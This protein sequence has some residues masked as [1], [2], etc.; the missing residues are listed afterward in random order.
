[1]AGGKEGMRADGLTPVSEI[2]PQQFTALGLK[3]HGCAQ[4]DLWMAALTRGDGDVVAYQFDLPVYAPDGGRTTP[5][6]VFVAASVLREAWRPGD[7]YEALKP[8]RAAIDK[9]LAVTSAQLAYSSYDFAAIHAVEGNVAEGDVARVS[10]TARALASDWPH[11]L[12]PLRAGIN[13]TGEA[14]LLPEVS[15]AL[16]KRFGLDGSV[17]VAGSVGRLERGYWIEASTAVNVAP[18]D[19]LGGRLSIALQRAGVRVDG[20]AAE[21]VGS[22][23]VPP[24]A[25]GLSG[26]ITLD[27]QK[28]AVGIELDPVAAQLALTADAPEVLRAGALLKSL[29]PE[30]DTA[31][32]GVLGTADKVVPGL[33]RLALSTPLDGVDG[34]K[35]A[36]WLTYAEPFTLFD[37]IRV[38]PSLFAAGTYS[39]S[40][41]SF[42]AELSGEGIIGSGALAMRFETSLSLPDG[43][44]RAGAVGGEVRLPADVAGKLGKV[45]GWESLRLIDLALTG[46]TREGAYSFT[47]VTLGFLDFRIGGGTLSIGDVRFEVGK[48]RGEGLTAQLEASL[49]IGDVEADVSIDIDKGVRGTVTVPVLPIG[50]LAADLLQIE[51]PGDLAAVEINGFQLDIALGEQTEFAFSAESNSPFTIAGLRLTLGKL[52]VRYAGA[53]SLQGRGQIRLDATDIALNLDYAKENWNFSFSADTRVDLGRALA[54]LAQHL[55]FTPPFEEG[56]VTVSRVAG[57]LRLGSEGTRLA[58]NFEFRL[59]DGDFRLTLVAARL[60]EKGWEYSLKIGPVT[61]DFRSLPVVG[62][63]IR[64]GVEAFAKDGDAKPVGVDGLRVGVL[65]T[66]DA[67]TLAALFKNLPDQDFP[68]PPRDVAGKL[69]LTGTLQLLDYSKPIIYPKP[70]ADETGKQADESASQADEAEKAK[71]DKNVKPEVEVL[72]PVAA[73]A[74]AEPDAKPADDLSW[75]TVQRDCGPLHLSKLGYG[76]RSAEGSYEVTAAL[77]GKV[78]VAGVQLELMDAGVSVRLNALTAPRGRLKGMSLSFKRGAVA[79]EGGFLQMSET[80]YGGQLNIQLPKVSMGVVGVYGSYKTPS[81]GASTSLFIYGTA[82]LTG[83]AGI[84]LGALTL[85]GLALGFGLNRRVMVPEIGGVAD[86]PLVALVMKDSA[87]EAPQPSAMEMLTTLERHLPFAEGQ[88]FAALGLRFTI[89]EAIDAFALAIGQFGREV[90]FSLLGLA[91]FEKSVG[92]QK[93]C[94]VELA[95]KMTLRPEEGVFL[96][97]AELTTNSWV[98]D[99][100]CRLTGGFALG[101]WFAGTRKGD[102]VLTLGGYHRD[103]KPPAHYPAVPR[104]GLNWAVTNELTL[105]GE[106]YCALTP[107]HL[108]AGG[109]FEASFIHSRIKAWFIAAVDFLLRWAPL[110]YSLDAGISI[111][112]EAD[113]SLF[114][115]NLS[116]DVQLRLWGP[117][118]AG[119]VRVKLSVLSFEIAFGGAPAPAEIRGWAQ[120]GALFL[121]KASPHWQAVPLPGLPVEAPAICGVVLTGGR[122]AQ[123]DD[124]QPSGPWRVRGDE[125]SVSIASVLPA[126]TLVLGTL[127]GAVPPKARSGTNLALAAPLALEAV[128][129][130]HAAEGAALGIV[131]LSITQA[132][133]RLTIG[134]VRDLAG[135]VTVAVDLAGWHSEAERQGMPAALWDRQKPGDAPA[136]KLTGAYLTGLA[137]LAPPPGRRRGEGMRAALARHRESDL[138]FRAPA[139]CEPP[140]QAARAGAPAPAA[141]GVPSAELLKTL[142]ALGFPVSL[143]ASAGEA[144]R[145][146]H[147]PLHRAWPEGA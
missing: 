38:T 75:V 138:I 1:M 81:G 125:L 55:G 83:G 86:F 21:G 137:R 87:A 25:L 46:N 67:A 49:V 8:A 127:A 108:M 6:R 84:K 100:S 47:I 136:A 97:Q 121:D 39:G 43:A 118:F 112:V 139:L 48:R 88:I 143:E 77:A 140:V 104:L 106:L 130:T 119:R 117:P 129:A 68:P 109:R 92:S 80:V 40:A 70:K 94:R 122:L 18:L 15:P 31:L 7:A 73:P 128:A 135:G 12:T 110:Q 36:V 93:F 62:G 102:F 26:T 89:A 90:E 141:A 103:F 20:V 124:R 29:A 2:D 27:T 133:S 144:R 85:T 32:G 37:L 82:S 9:A 105:K 19:L 33:R 11:A 30:L 24:F 52:D 107:S 54:P 116:L 71:G 76:V 51:A 72:P 99:P 147:P 16:R 66:L 10:A 96:L 64:A 91:R 115:I 59:N 126:T 120:F 146:R 61:L 95:I 13:F 114:S 132:E 42:E 134:L 14:S 65:S 79:V 28:L 142:G 78:S 3:D 35:L 58:L 113:L 53:L 63:A 23:E 34:A 5:T 17:R 131:P 60:G 22:S 69:S 4:L 98:L 74:K 41:F 145:L 44:F 123:P 50:A 56:R 45:A 57:A 101:V 111:R